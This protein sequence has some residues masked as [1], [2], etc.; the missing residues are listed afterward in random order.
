MTNKLLRLTEIIQENF[1]EKLVEVFK[2]NEKSSLAK[3]LAIVN[4]AID[5]HQNR[6]ATLW[7]QAGRKRT[8]EERHAAAQAELAGFVFA[9]LTGDAKEYADS[10]IEAMRALGRHGEVDLIRSLSKHRRVGP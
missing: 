5:S 2:A 3:R 4:K 7:L 1:P 6:A 9:Y 8:A 10:G